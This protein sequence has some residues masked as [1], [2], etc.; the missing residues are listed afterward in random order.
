MSFSEA[1]LYYDDLAIGQQWES[2]GRTL[3]ESDIVNFAGIS[4][5]FNPIHVD[6]E[7]AKSTP[8]RRPIAHGLLVFSIASGLGVQSPPVRTMAFLRVLEWVFHEPVFIG[9]TLRIRN[10]ILEVTERGRGRRAEILW[11][12]EIL[13]QAGK[14]VQSGRLVTLVEGRGPNRSSVSRVTVPNEPVPMQ[15]ES[16][17][18]GSHRQG[19]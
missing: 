11:H 7:F 13:N 15:P 17:V 8:F 18:P 4:G 12:R 16:E 2:F 5:D 1:H 14:V 6:H 19:E 3:T 9:D 10:R